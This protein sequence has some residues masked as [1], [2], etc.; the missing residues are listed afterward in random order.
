MKRILIIE[1]EKNLARFIELELKYEGYEVKVTNDGREGLQSALQEDW[2]VVLLDLML[3]SLNGMEV[4]RRLRQEK[5]TP[6]IMITARDS[7]IDRVSGLD[8]GAD[9]YIVKPFA[10][11]ELL[12]R[13]RSIFR[14]IEIHDPK[15]QLTSY[16]FRDL[17]VEKESRIVKKNDKIIDVTK[18]EYDL[19]LTLLEN[20][21][22]VMTR[23]VLLNKVW[24]YET[25]VET[26]VVDVYIRYL[27]NKI[28]N[29]GEES[30]IQT[31][32]GTGY[33]MRE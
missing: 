33:V 22:I 9:D 30:Y 11:E 14:R 5:D 12:A 15:I 13:L 8:H 4:C 31:V 20:K 1:D 25:E 16:T 23:E 2:D 26:N 10:I 7:V 21:N 28:D 3:P 19:L 17:F 6:I 29:P 32:R 24:G 27:R 18:R